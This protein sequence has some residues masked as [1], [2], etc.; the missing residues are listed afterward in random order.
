[1][2]QVFSPKT[3]SFRK[4]IEK[5]LGVKRFPFPL[6]NTFGQFCSFSKAK[7][8]LHFSC[9]IQTKNKSPFL[10]CLITNTSDVEVCS[11]K[12]VIE[13]NCERYMPAKKNFQ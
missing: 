3:I 13:N 6:F 8:K 10:T 12:R 11:Y 5:T 1:M 4:N 9:Y 7:S 2:R